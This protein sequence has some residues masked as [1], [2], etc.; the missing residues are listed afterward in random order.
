LHIAILVISSA[1]SI[2]GAITDSGVGS[3]L[4]RF[5]AFIFLI[6]SMV[7]VLK[8]K[9]H[10]IAVLDDIRNWFDQKIGPRK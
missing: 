7:R 2:L 8:G 6:V 4:F 3:G 10:H 1:F 9:P 5:A